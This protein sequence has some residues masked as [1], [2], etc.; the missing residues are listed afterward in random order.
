MKNELCEASILQH[1]RQYVTKSPKPDM[2]ARV[3]IMKGQPP[4]INR[5]RISITSR[6][7]VEWAAPIPSY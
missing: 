1:F 3:A 7:G 5:K 4:V 2:Q 6:F